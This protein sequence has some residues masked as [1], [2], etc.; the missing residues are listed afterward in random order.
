MPKREDYTNE[1]DYLRAMAEFQYRIANFLWQGFDRLHSFTEAE[2]NDHS[3]RDANHS[4]CAY[5]NLKQVVERSG[6]S[7]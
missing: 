4:Q 2:R 6:W 3:L 1:L 7:P 5:C